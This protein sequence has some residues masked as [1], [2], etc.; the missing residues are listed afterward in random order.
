MKDLWVFDVLEE[1][2]SSWVWLNK[3]WWHWTSDFIFNWNLLNKNQILS[4]K[5]NWNLGQKEI[6]IDQW[7]N[8]K[9][10]QA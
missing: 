9:Q 6:K 1:F 7:V 4:I 5:S 8:D 10:I 3:L 2:S